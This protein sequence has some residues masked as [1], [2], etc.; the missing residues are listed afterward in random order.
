M[1]LR[2]QT[3]YLE[4]SHAKTL[5][6]LQK[7]T[8]RVRNLKNKRLTTSQTSV[9][10]SIMREILKLLKRRHPSRSNPQRL[11]WSHKCKHLCHLS[12]WHPHHLGKWHP[13][14]LV[15]KRPLHLS[16]RHQ[17]HLGRCHKLNRWHRIYSNKDHPCPRCPPYPQKLSKS[18]LQD[19]K[20][21]SLCSGLTSTRQEGQKTLLAMQAL[22]HMLRNGW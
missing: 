12:K 16:R 8:L 22:S 6:R 3:S 2:T 14:R 5:L 15:R 19:H 13:L 17:L 11:R 20:N 7:T 4:G 9:S 18:S 10:Y 21:Q 1:L